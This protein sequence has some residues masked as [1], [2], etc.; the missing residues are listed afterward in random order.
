MKIIRTFLLQTDFLWTNKYR[1]K[2]SFIYKKIVRYR[3]M[4]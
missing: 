2:L 4:G 3:Q 1:N